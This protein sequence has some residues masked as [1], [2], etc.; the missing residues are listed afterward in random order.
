M[1]PSTQNSH[2]KLRRVLWGF[3]GQ[4]VARKS[5]RWPW[6]LIGRGSVCPGEGWLLSGPTSTW[7]SLVPL[8]R[9]AVAVMVQRPGISAARN[10]HQPDWGVW[11]AGA[12]AFT[13]SKCDAIKDLPV[14]ELSF[15]WLLFG[16]TLQFFFSLIEFSEPCIWKSVVSHFLFA[17]FS[18]LFSI[19]S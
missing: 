16:G 19:F 5:E 2:L 1:A 18:N 15:T 10:L 12:E 13:N 14:I 6:R 4:A 8:V 11:L 17:L 3:R 7:H 9:E